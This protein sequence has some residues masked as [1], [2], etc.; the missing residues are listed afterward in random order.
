MKKNLFLWILSILFTGATFAQSPEIGITAGLNVSNTTLFKDN[1][2]KPGFQ[3][4]VV[5][6]FSIAK[7]F[8]ILPEFLFSQRGFKNKNVQLVDSQGNWT[9][10][11]LTNTYNY[12]QL[13]INAAY[14]FDVG[15]DAKVI[16]FAG[17][18]FGYAV[19]AKGNSW[20]IDIGSNGSLNRFD[21]GMNVGV[22]YQYE[23]I[24]VKLQYN[25]GLINVQNPN[26]IID[27]QNSN[28]ASSMRNMN[29]AVTAGYFF[30]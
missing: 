19:S 8:S 7:N 9:G 28:N 16:V 23:K 21:F 11:T 5:A 25:Q 2:F 6:D 24:F 15:N 18:Y 20:N 4:G 12:L 1:S 27:E 3:A 10:E 26:I 29:I 17:P 13:P 22:G 14:K 30:N